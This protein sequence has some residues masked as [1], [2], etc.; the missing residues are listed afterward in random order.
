MCVLVAFMDVTTVSIDLPKIGDALHAGLGALEWVIVGYLAV[1]AFGMLFVPALS[2]RFGLR[3]LLVLGL[4]LFGAASAAAAW[5]PGIGWLI[6]CRILM[7]VG[8]ATILPTRVAVTAALFEPAERRR[9]MGI[10]TMSVA[11]AMPIG[12]VIGGAL[13]QGFWW[14]S[15]FLINVGIVAVAVPL[16]LRFV[17]E[18][19]GA[20][21]VVDTASIW[22]F[23]LSA[24]SLLYGVI[25]LRRPTG[26]VALVA[27][28]LLVAGF[29]AR[30]R[31]AER[32]LLDL[33]AL[34]HPGFVW[35]QV[36]I[37][38]GNLAWNGAMFVVPMYLQIAL[39]TDPIGAGI[40]LL[41]F[42]GFVALGSLTSDRIA[43][44]VGGRAVVVGGL[45]LVAAGFG[46][47]CWAVTHGSDPL[48]TI[49][50]GVCG[51]GGGL[52]QAP[53]LAA[54]L[55]A[56]APERQASGGAFIN[57]SRN[58]G[59]AFGVAL[60]GL[61][62]AAVYRA[63]PGTSTAVPTSAATAGAADGGRDAV[64]AAFTDGVAAASF[65]LALLLSAA[66]VLALV[67]RDRAAR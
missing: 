7:G 43:R 31:V 3:R 24:M 55:A 53:A 50:L 20:R 14:G 28:A 8:A 17:P 16:I 6:V 67:L 59:G 5:S 46:L 63:E 18:P 19:P 22:L 1:C 66:A 49:A 57:A 65:G 52:P 56:L 32:P 27:G 44:R 36:V 42:A 62:V 40:R 29:V 61:T 15:V 33:A 64:V 38:L 39:G 41:P 25:E 9:A 37:T 11:L 12:P 23:S 4:L 35:S 54:A 34:R 13:L 60:V 10:G 58:L 45:L 47:L 48:V 2:R 51:L 30:Q 21:A 26:L